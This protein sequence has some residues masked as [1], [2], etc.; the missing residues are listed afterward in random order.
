MNTLYLITGPAGVGKSTISKELARRKEKSVLIEGD[1]IYHQ[2]IGGYISAWKEGNHLNIFWKVCIETI[3]IYLNAGY[4]VIFN[5]II[6][7]NGLDNLKTEF[8]NY[9]I[10]FVCLL[11]SET[12]LIKR[13]K[14]RTIDCQMGDRCLVLL[15]AFKNKKFNSNNF[16]NTHDLSVLEVVE[17]IE[18]E[19][20]YI[21]K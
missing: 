20:K 9:H 8:S 1:D 16:L 12:D 5:Y 3:K 7:E 17:E 21:L 18:K 15:N 2:V 14:E 11:T 10:K 4:D 13:D 19:E 6:D